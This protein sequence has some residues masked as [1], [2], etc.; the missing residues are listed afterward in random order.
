[1]KL[2][3]AILSVLDKERLKRRLDE[4][5]IG[6]ADRRSAEAMRSALKS[7]RRVTAESLLASLRL[8]VRPVAT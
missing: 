6:N 8:P 4:Q 3:A 5:E 2:K 1:M 7:S